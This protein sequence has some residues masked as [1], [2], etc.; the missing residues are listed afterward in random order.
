MDR[1]CKDHVQPVVYE[2][3]STVSYEKSPRQITMAGARVS[4]RSRPKHK[5]LSSIFACHKTGVM[6]ERDCRDVIEA[7]NQEDSRPI[8]RLPTS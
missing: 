5:C 6:F 1:V 4:Y 3:C 8:L 2:D 7:A